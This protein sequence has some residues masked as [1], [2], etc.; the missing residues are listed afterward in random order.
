MDLKIGWNRE[1]AEGDL[2]VS[3]TALTLDDGLESAVLL[4]LFLDR[5]APDTG[6]LEPGEDPRGALIDSLGGINGDEMGSLLWLLERRVLDESARSDA[7][8]WARQSLTW[9]LEDGVASSLDV[10]AELQPPDRIGISVTITEPS[11]TAKRFSFV[12]DARRAA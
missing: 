11:G 2:S 7:E 5:R 8:A 4:S 9:M 10:T 1:L 3:G 6:L 12:W